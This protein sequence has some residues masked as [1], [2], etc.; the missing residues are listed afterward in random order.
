MIP[1]R[2]L[3]VLERISLQLAAGRIRREVDVALADALDHVAAGDDAALADVHDRLNVIG[4][5]EDADRIRRL[6][7]MEE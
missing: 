4:R 2:R 7:G 3:T 1:L 6:L 5:P